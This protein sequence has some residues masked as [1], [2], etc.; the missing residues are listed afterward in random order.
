MA[1]GPEVR[2]GERILVDI[3]FA[4]RIVG[5][6]PGVDL[7]VGAVDRLRGGGL[8]P[9]GDDSGDDRCEQIGRPGRDPRRPYFTG[10]RIHLAHEPPGDLFEGAGD[11]LAVDWTD[12][13]KPVLLPRVEAP[14]DTSGFREHDLSLPFQSSDSEQPEDGAWGVDARAP[15]SCGEPSFD[16]AYPGSVD[17]GESSTEELFI[18]RCGVDHSPAPFRSQTS[19]SQRP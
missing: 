6:S 5:P 4:V 17:D 13:P 12:E 10:A 8:D 19:S 1:H 2:V 9:V 7:D 16:G 18:Y 15:G 11:L 3:R 14:G